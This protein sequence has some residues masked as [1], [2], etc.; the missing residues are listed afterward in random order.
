VQ[1]NPG[2]EYQAGVA[3]DTGFVA[4]LLAP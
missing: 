3:T 4:A 1:I 2:C